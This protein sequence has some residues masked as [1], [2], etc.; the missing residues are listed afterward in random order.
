[1]EQAGDAHRAIET[2]R[3]RGKIVLTID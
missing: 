1:M 2:R 3:G